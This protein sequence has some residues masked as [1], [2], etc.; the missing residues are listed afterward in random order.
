MCGCEERCR[1]KTKEEETLDRTN[2]SCFYSVY[3]RKRESL[4]GQKKVKGGGK[5][6]F[7][8]ASRS[9]TVVVSVDSSTLLLPTEQVEKQ[10][11]QPE[12]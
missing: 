8:K 12:R 3:Q 1:K 6:N 7:L 5:L 4:N 10:S 9:P 2:D 11:N